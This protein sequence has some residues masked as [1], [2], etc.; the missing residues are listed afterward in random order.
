MVN[1]PNGLFLCSMDNTSAALL[2]ILKYTIPALIV[3]ASSYLVVNKFLVSQ[4]QRKQLS[5]FQDSQNITISLRLQAYE[6]LVI[7]V[8]R[9]SPRQ[10]LPRIYDSSMTVMDL[11][12]AITFSILA[13]YEHNLSQQIYVSKEVWE[14][15]KNVKEQEITMANQVAARLD[16]NAPAK[17]LHKMIMDY[18]LGAEDQLPTDVALTVINGEVRKVMAYGSY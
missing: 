16:P 11:R 13:E 10:L 15:V 18:V 3:L 7:F 8:E 1:P 2:D 9:I 5:L 4:M 17:D 6:R 12:T 14:T